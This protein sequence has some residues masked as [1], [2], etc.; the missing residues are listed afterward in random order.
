M[1]TTKMKKLAMFFVALMTT[2]SLSS[3]LGDSETSGTSAWYGI[4]EVGGYYGSYVFYLSDGTYIVP[5]N[6]SALSSS[7]SSYSFAYIVA[8][9]DVEDLETSTTYI[10]MEIYGISPIKTCS[11]S[12]DVA[13]MEVFSNI[14]IKSVTNNSS[15]GYI[16]FYSAYDMFVPISYYYLDSDDVDTHDFT[17]YYD[18]DEADE[19]TMYF[20]LRHNVEDDSENSSRVTYGTEYVHFR[21]TS[22]ISAYLSSFGSVPTYIAVDYPYNYSGAE[23]EDATVITLSDEIEYGEIYESF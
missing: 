23:I 10:N 7:L 21:I 1:K 5:T 20:H 2:I 14:A 6:Q 13:D 12:A 15:D 18:V 17:I 4:V 19:T 16:S 3:C 11:V 9:Y 8:Y 22:P